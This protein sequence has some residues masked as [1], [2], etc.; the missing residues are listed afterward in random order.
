M[1]WE[2]WG[3]VSVS[4]IASP[5][6]ILILEKKYSDSDTQRLVLNNYHPQCLGERSFNY[7][8]KNRC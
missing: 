6:K 2:V 7:G 1:T 3:G 5:E 8:P 4:L